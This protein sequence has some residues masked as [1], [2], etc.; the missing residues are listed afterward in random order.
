MYT[1]EDLFTYMVIRVEVWKKLLGKGLKRN[2]H[3]KPNFGEELQQRTHNL[4]VRI[5]N[6][7]K[8]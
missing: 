6:K 1:E 3:H 2:Q 4:A 5:L 8:G 7:Q